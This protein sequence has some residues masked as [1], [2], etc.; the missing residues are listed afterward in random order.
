MPAF[1]L[2]CGFNLQAFALQLRLI[3]ML[4][5]FFFS[6]LRRCCVFGAHPPPLLKLSV[7]VLRVLNEPFPGAL[8]PRRLCSP[9][10]RLCGK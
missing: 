8:S 2:F 7:I 1:G 9:L 3:E 10:N 5:D 6:I 4:P